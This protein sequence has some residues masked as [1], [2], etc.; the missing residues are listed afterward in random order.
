LPYVDPVFI[1]HCNAFGFKHLFMPRSTARITRCQTALFVHNSLPWQLRIAKVCDATDNA[2]RPS[3]TAQRRQL[4]VSH[5][6]AP[7]NLRYQRLDLFAKISFNFSFQ[8]IP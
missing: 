3:I 1:A 7:R 2:R 8:N 4:P 6:P 5:N